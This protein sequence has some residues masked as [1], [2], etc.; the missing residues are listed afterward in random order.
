M[1]YYTY[2]LKSSKDH[3]RYIGNTNDLERR[4]RQHN[5]G[6]NSSTKNRRPFEVLCCKGFDSKI[7]ALRYEKYLKKLKGGKQLQIEIEN[8]QMPL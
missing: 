6:L 8:M 2:I 5:E 4:L 7:E 1:K 3:K